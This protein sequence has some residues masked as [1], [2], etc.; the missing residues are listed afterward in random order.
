MSQHYDR[1]A[2][3]W[4]IGTI[5]YQCLTGKA[6]FTAES[7]QALKQFY[8]KHVNLVPD[9]PGSTSPQLRDL[10]LK[11][12]RRNPTDRINFEDFLAHEFLLTVSTMT[13]SCTG[14]GIGLGGHGGAH[15]DD[16]DELSIQ[17]DLVDHNTAA[18]AVAEPSLISLQQPHVQQQQQQQQQSLSHRTYQLQM[19]QQQQQQQQQPLPLQP[20][21]TQ[22]PSRRS[23][24]SSSGGSP[25]PST[26][27]AAVA[28]VNQQERE[29]ND[30]IVVFNRDKDSK[31][32]ANLTPNELLLVQQQ[33]KISHQQ[34]QQQQ[35]HEDTNVSAN[36]NNN[37]SND[38]TSKLISEFN[39]FVLTANPASGSNRPTAGANN[40]A[41]TL[42]SM[43]VPSQ[44]ENYKMME[45]GFSNVQQQ[46]QLAS[47]PSAHR[48]MNMDSVDNA[49]YS[50][51]PFQQL[52]H[53]HQQPSLSPSPLAK[54]I[55]I[56]DDN[57]G[58]YR[59][60]RAQQ[61]DE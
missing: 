27:A 11:M 56:N 20:L 48:L 60:R 24:G 52:Q 35:Q 50:P 37:N 31:N 8:E 40:T 4:S 10:L 32:A 22:A 47:S 5:A 28:A 18:V 58:K 30:Y 19:Q 54:C 3:L 36:S 33:Q 53:F 26:I 44:K 13:V 38:P 55:F 17:D 61:R 39:M 41:Y 46:Q 7:P 9:I 21:A 12:L 34:Q 25:R 42:D 16:D 15:D 29:L 51:H 6:P 23:A 49:A 57:A 43:P 2:D 45:K 14:S 1:K 59:H